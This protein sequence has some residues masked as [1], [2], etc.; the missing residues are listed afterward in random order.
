MTVSVAC[1]DMQ[2]FSLIR[3]IGRPFSGTDPFRT[4]FGDGGANPQ[5]RGGQIPAQQELTTSNL[6][7]PLARWVG[8]CS[9]RWA[10]MQMGGTDG[11]LSLQ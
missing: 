1:A 6:S 9:D 11:T 5:L 4:L 3:F 7:K 10:E 2:L 8:D